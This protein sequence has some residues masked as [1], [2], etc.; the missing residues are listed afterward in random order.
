MI[1]RSIL[2]RMRNSSDKCVEKIKTHILCS[3]KFFRKSCRLW[4]NVEKYGRARQATD[5]NIIGRMCF[6]CCITKAKTHTKNMYY[7]L[8]FHG[9]NGY[10]N[11]PQWYAIR[12]LPPLLD[13]TPFGW[14]RSISLTQNGGRSPGMYVASHPRWWQPSQ[15]TPRENE[16]LH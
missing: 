4:D 10:A 6:A 13:L 16:I 3:M 7:L 15:Q 9:N 14:L 8:L 5:D 2:L 11:A 1:S 12:K